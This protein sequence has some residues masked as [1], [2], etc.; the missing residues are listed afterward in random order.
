[1]AFSKAPNYHDLEPHRR[2][3][4]QERPPETHHATPFDEFVA[5]LASRAAGQTAIGPYRRSPDDGPAAPATQ[6][7][8]TLAARSPARFESTGARD[9]RVTYVKAPGAVCL[10]PAGIT[11]VFKAH[12]EF[13]LLV[14]ALDCELVR[15]V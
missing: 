7:I 11:H 1:M 12:S 2:Q 15:E 4:G 6:H 14:L 9:E 10:V 13:E 8:L 5:D 3:R